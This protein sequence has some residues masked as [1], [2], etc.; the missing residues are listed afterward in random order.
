MHLCHILAIAF[1][2][3]CHQVLGASFLHAAVFTGCGVPWLTS[4]TT[5]IVSS[6][7]STGGSSKKIPE[8]SKFEKKLRYNV[9]RFAKILLDELQESDLGS[10]DKNPLLTWL[11]ND[12]G[13]EYVENLQAKNLHA[14]SSED[15]RSRLQNFLVW[16]RQEFPYY[17]DQCDNCHAK[18]CKFQGNQAPTEEERMR[19]AFIDTT[20]VYRCGKCH[21]ITRFPR[22]LAATEIVRRR[23]GRCTEYSLLLYQILRALGHKSRWIVDW[24]NHVWAEVWMDDRWVH[25]DPCEASMDTPLLYQ[26]WG[27]KQT[28]I[29]AFEAPLN[30]GNEKENDN[31]ILS[32]AD[33]TKSYTSDNWGSIQARRSEDGTTFDDIDMSLQRANKDMKELSLSEIIAQGQ[34]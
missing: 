32:I 18:G 3:G 14:L 29:V 15:Q 28:Y 13:T 21:K 10:S 22:Y 9:D 4:T 17:R 6:S 2:S 23:R 11:Q 30:T 25:L 34:A 7:D 26:R 1:L 19:S 33:V 8:R 5:M 20:E 24:A 27:K 31:N 16:F 12:Y